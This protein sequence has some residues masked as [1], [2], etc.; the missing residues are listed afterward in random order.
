M[1]RFAHRTF[2]LKCEALAK[3]FP[4]AI[5]VSLPKRGNALAR[6]FKWTGSTHYGYIHLGARDHDDLI[7]QA[8]GASALV[9]WP[10]PVRDVTAAT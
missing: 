8:V 9:G 2:R 6:D 5:F 10:A 7:A 3:A 1:R 4:D